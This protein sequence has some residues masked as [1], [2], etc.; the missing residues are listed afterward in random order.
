MVHAGSCN[1]KTYTTVLGLGQFVRD[2]QSAGLRVGPRPPRARPAEKIAAGT[3]LRV[4]IVLEIRCPQVDLPG[5]HR[6][7]REGVLLDLD[8][9][10]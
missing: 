4:A 10:T 7:V 3:T 6:L 5:D 1:A 9:L 8:L 2:S